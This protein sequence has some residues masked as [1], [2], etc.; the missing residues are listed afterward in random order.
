MGNE[1]NFAPTLVASVITAFRDG[2]AAALKESFGKLMSL[3]AIVRRYG[4][5]SLRGLKPML[6]AF[7]LPGGTLREPRLPL[8]SGE[9][10]KMAKA[11][12]ALQI[13]GAPVLPESH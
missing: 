9:V 7:G 1:G 6:N 8:D 4:G 12:A 5:S 3:A 11:V 13:P 2:N 10:E